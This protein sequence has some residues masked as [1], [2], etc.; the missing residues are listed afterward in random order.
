MTQVYV[1]IPSYD[2]RVHDGVMSA[3]LAQ[4]RGKAGFMKFLRVESGS[5]LCRNFNILY[6]HALNLREEQGITHFCL[7]HE[8]LEPEDG[9]WLQ[10]MVQLATE[11]KADVLS[12][13]S[14]LKCD[15]GLTSTALDE[16]GV[17]R[18]L[19]LHEAYNDYPATFTEP[20]L[21][22]NTGLMLI[23]ITKPWA[24]E[25]CFT[26]IDK[27]IKVNGQFEAQGTPEDWN[28]SRFARS[29]GASIWATR[30]IA[31]THNGGGH[32]GNWGPWGSLKKDVPDAQPQLELVK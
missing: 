2:G 20:N 4:M 5:W 32:W 27:I 14:P 13:I 1:G 30:E 16:F 6:A 12:V 17:P 31:V 9:E 28:F 22:I 15:K 25:V 7:L 26:M 24:E 18:R 29:K 19:T 10:K 3:V 21:L 8:D 11:R 23:D